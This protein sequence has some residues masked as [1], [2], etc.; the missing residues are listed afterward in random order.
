MA[1]AQ[2]DVSPDDAL[3]ISLF[4]EPPLTTNH[5]VDSRFSQLTGDVFLQ[6]KTLN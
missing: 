2:S 4:C 3:Q 6:T 1:I 5:R